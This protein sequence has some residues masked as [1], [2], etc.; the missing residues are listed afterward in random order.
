MIFAVL[1]PASTHRMQCSFDPFCQLL[2]EAQAFFNRK[3]FNLC[4]NLLEKGILNRHVPLLTEYTLYSKL[5]FSI[6]HM[7]HTWRLADAQSLV[8]RPG[9]N[10]F[11]QDRDGDL[12]RLA[13][14][15]VQADRGVDAGDL[16]IAQAQLSQPFD[17]AGVR[18][19]GT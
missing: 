8:L 7:A 10:N 12:F 17:A 6:D 5:H 15:D 4:G 2:Y 19:L 16:R 18:A 1:K 11:R 9:R 14:T 3:E 13:R